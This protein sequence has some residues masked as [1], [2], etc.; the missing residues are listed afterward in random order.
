[1]AQIQAGVTYVNGGQVNAT[2]L[3]AHVNNAVLV[4]GAISDQAAAASCTTADS[5]LILQSGALKKATLTQVQAVADLTPYLLRSGASPMTGELTLSSS[6]PA[7]TLSAASKGYVDT[8]L[9]TKQASLGFT[10]VN[11]AGDTSVGPI[12]L[13][14][15]PV[16]ALQV[17][18][19]QY[20]DTGLATK[21]ASLGF[22]PVNKAGD[23]GVG[24]LAL[25]ADPAQP[26]EAATKQYVDTG[27]ATKQATLGFTPLNKA[28]D[29][30][31]GLLVLSGDATANL[32][33]VTKQ[34]LDA[35]TSVRT[36]VNFN[37]GKNTSGVLDVTG[38][39]TN[40]S[41]LIRGSLNVASVVR[42][43]V[44]DYT[45]NFTA[46]LVD[47]NYL[48]IGSGSWGSQQAGIAFIQIFPDINAAGTYSPHT[49]SSCRIIS[50]DA[51]SG[52]T[53]D[54]EN[55]YISIIR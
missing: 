30:M 15:D 43:G 54:A 1:M 51:L 40:T 12:A 37:G 3:N 42:N 38:V 13:A 55:I 20:V 25:A 31:T 7:A 47:T 49:T 50:V 4:P 45:I 46:P 11:K 2:N 17:T 6:L 53:F 10:P 14:A 32:N 21:Q 28:G 27:L 18:T 39:V 41:R 34:Q 9:A 48:I 22:T 52:P 36:W 24:P 16:S 26:L 5:V 33:P 35:S 44:G 29:T 19:K 23:T 8:G